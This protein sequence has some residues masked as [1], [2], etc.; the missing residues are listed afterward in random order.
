MGD[1]IR[2]HACSEVCPPLEPVER[3]QI[4]TSPT[5]PDGG[6][7]YRVPDFSR[8]MALLAAGTILAAGVTLSGCGAGNTNDD[9]G[10]GVPATATVLPASGTLI[11]AQRVIV[12]KFDRSMDPAS[13]MLGGSLAAEGAA[14]WSKGSAANDTLTITPSS[15][16][17]GGTHTL[18]VDAL[19]TSN[20]A[21]ETVDVSY[22]IDGIAPTILSISPADGSTISKSQQIVIEFSEPMEESSLTLGGAL[23]GE[24]NGGIWGKATAA[25]HAVTISPASLWSGGAENLTVS[26]RDVAGN[27]LAPATFNYTVDVNAA[28]ATPALADGSLL[29]SDG[30]ITID[31]SK[32]MDAGSL[33]VGG[34][35]GSESDGGV[36]STDTMTN[37]R[38][39]L[40]PSA[41]WSD[42]IVQLT[43]SVLDLLGNES[44]LTLTYDVNVIFVATSGLDANLG[45]HSTPKKTIQAGIDAAVDTGFTNVWVQNGT[46]TQVVSLAD[47]VNVKGGHDA[48]W[49]YATGSR[50]STILNGNYDS[51]AGQYVTVHA[52][53]ITT[54]TTLST[55]RINGPTAS[56]ACGSAACSSY[57]LHAAGSTSLRLD[58]LN[59]VGGTGADGGAG[60]S[61]TALTTTAAGG[62]PGGNSGGGST[63]CN[64]TTRGAGGSPGTS[65]GTRNGGKGGD[66]GLMD[67]ACPYTDWNATSGITGSA[68]TINDATNGGG[69]SGGSPCGIGG[70]GKEG[71]PGTAGAN[72]T[73]AAP[74]SG[75][76]D[77]VYWAATGVGGAGAPGGDGGGGGGGGGSGGCDDTSPDTY[78]AGGG[79]GGAGGLG[80][81]TGGAGGKAGGWSFALFVTG[82]GTVTLIDVDVTAGT[83]GDGGT[84]GTGAA[85]QAGGNPG[86]GGIKAGS[87]QPGGAGGKGGD[88]GSS[89][90]GAGGAGGSAYG[91]ATS[92]SATV[93]VTGGSITGGSAGLGGMS[94]GNSGNAGSVVT[95]GSL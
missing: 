26:G 16:W 51:N 72:G 48:S 90:H 31:F 57:A 77:G 5:R 73:A 91:I 49:T 81:S 56:G 41:T 58:D 60:T 54:A 10:M 34:V 80:N 6:V 25:G 39:T 38:L 23:G 75:S 17:P 8:A 62:Y 78:G 19:D 84:G 61:A 24:D 12:V 30:L 45:S 50:D 29:A 32:P 63:A 1:S 15:G 93:D 53:G 36:W 3:P 42:G 7:P 74:T 89:G 35:L 71:R 66:G 46:Y 52:S 85:G 87:G 33:S 92:D 79:G 70:D 95:S 27:A 82:T 44:T 4:R 11:S 86:T 40:S 13:L 55:M 37:D 28:T 47:G 59:L 21:A 14:T 69:G 88:G 2:G 76:L 22:P 43:V 64:N 18:T 9:A 68:A 65:G 83:G 94:S 67:T 20:L